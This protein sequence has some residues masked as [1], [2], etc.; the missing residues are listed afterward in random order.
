[1][2]YQELTDLNSID[3]ILRAAEKS[4]ALA[5]YSQKIQVL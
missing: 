4:V 2:N 5:F 1:M 3:D